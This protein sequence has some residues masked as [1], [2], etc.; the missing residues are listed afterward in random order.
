MVAEQTPAGDPGDQPDRRSP[1]GAQD[2]P[3]QPRFQPWPADTWRLEPE[4][5]RLAPTG[6]RP[7]DLGDEPVHEVDEPDAQ[8][9]DAPRPD[10]QRPD[11]QRP[12]GWRTEADEAWL[13]Q[14]SSSNFARW[15]RRL[16]RLGIVGEALSNAE[17]GPFGGPRRNPELRRTDKAY[18]VIRYTEHH[19]SYTT[20]HID[21]AWCR[22]CGGR[23]EI[24]QVVRRSERVGE[25]VIGEVRGC[26]RCDAGSWL[27]E[28]HMPTTRR[29]R[30]RSRYTVL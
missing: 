16:A 3:N 18:A 4:P 7:A 30:A 21:L 12:D 20:V 27:F 8:R 11:A 6:P 23:L 22:R 9:P 2:Q 14:H 15:R 17:L 24:H 28:S 19:I 29:A 5:T 26:R 1:D 13:A 25:Y 10:A